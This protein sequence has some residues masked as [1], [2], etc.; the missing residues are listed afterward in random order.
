MKTQVAPAAIKFIG[1]VLLFVAASGCRKERELKMPVDVSFVMD[2]SRNPGVNGQLYFQSGSI[3]VGQLNFEGDRIEGDDVYFTKSYPGGMEIPFDEDAVVAE[4]DFDIPQ[5]TYE[6]ITLQ[7]QSYG[8]PSE[9]RISVRG[10]Y[11][12][13]STFQSYPMILEIEADDV[14][15]INAVN[16]SGGNTI[17][18]DKDIP[19]KGTIRFS[20]TRWFQ[21]VTTSDLNNATLTIINN[22]PTILISDSVNEDIF[23]KVMDDLENSATLTFN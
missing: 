3:L 2:M 4:W 15:T 11:F 7:L 16:A 14:H 23:D 22:M 8:D 21:T 12:N 6:K 17:I 1:L 18:L 10:Y 13:T 9:E 19:A 20:P 5:G